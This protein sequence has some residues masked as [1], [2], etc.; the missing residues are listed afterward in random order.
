MRY[1]E[2]GFYLP[3][4]RRNKSSF[5]TKGLDFCP[6]CFL[7]LDSVKAIARAHIPP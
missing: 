3:F 4:R 7:Y 2:A 6:T 1:Y 5:F